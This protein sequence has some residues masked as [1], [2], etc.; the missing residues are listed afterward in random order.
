MTEPSTSEEAETAAL[1]RAADVLT[2]VLHD[3]QR[4]L[5]EEAVAQAERTETPKPRRPDPVPFVELT[6]YEGM[7]DKDVLLALGAPKVGF[8]YYKSALQ[9]ERSRLASSWS[10]DSPR[11]EAGV[12]SQLGLRCPRSALPGERWCRMHHPEP[13]VGVASPAEQARVRLRR[14]QLWQ[15]P[16]GRVLEAMYELTDRVDDLCAAAQTVMDRSHRLE[17]AAGERAT[18]AWLSA[19]EA[20]EYARRKRSAVTRAAAAGELSGVRQGVRGSWSFR[21]ADLDRWLES[22]KYNT[23]RYAPPRPLRRTGR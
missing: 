12:A 3:A 14:D 16:D 17:A 15:R 13:P 23:G 11:C 18:S 9:R 20:A 8:S 22:G 7:P 2:T 6:P 10:T 4:R 21:P 5:A 1:R 19:D